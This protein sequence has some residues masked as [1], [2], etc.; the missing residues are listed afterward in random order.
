[1]SPELGNLFFEHSLADFVVIGEGE[2]PFS[3]LLFAL[4]NNENVQDVRGN[5]L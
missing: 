2:K 5:S 1:M 4:A 3:N